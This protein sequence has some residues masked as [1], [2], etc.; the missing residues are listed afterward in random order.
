MCKLVN[1]WI[2]IVDNCWLKEHPSDI[3][4]AGNWKWRNFKIVYIHI[5][6]FAHIRTTLV[7]T[8]FP[9]HSIFVGFPT[10]Y[11]RVQCFLRAAPLLSIRPCKTKLNEKSK[12]VGFAQKIW[13]WPSILAQDAEAGKKGTSTANTSC[14]WVRWFDWSTRVSISTSHQFA[15]AVLVRWVG[16][17]KS[18]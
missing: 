2:S 17:E 6:I 8:S 3:Y 12:H 9:S 7:Y 1:I 13:F 11:P 16:L 10:K 14:W 15:V 4:N 18:K 5:W